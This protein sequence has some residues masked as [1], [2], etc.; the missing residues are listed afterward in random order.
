M[1]YHAPTNQFTIS[2]K[3]LQHASYSLRWAI[4]N[5]REGHSL[6][7]RG[8]KAPGAVS[9]PDLAEAG[10]L[11]AAKTLGIDLGADSPGQLDV[12]DAG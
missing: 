6:D 12:S 2:Q 11:G 10:I 5:I 9:A 7:T 8:Y 3:E 4:K 1:K